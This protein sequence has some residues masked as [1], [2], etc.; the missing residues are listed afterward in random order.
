M[1]LMINK[2]RISNVAIYLILFLF[3]KHNNT[4][5]SI[6]FYKISI[7]D[8]FYIIYYNIFINSIVK[9]IMKKCFIF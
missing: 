6:K 9:I 4:M 1:K 2:F 5:K 7:V 8:Y 3:G